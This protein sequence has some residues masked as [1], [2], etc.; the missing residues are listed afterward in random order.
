MGDRITM[1]APRFRDLVQAAS[2]SPC[3][4]ADPENRR[5]EQRCISCWALAQHIE[6]VRK[7]ASGGGVAA[8]Y[9]ARQVERL[10]EEQAF[11]AADLPRAEESLRKAREEEGNG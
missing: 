5:H 8:G 10:E 1:P 7:Y 2:I 6:R 3:L 9:F 11:R 4:C